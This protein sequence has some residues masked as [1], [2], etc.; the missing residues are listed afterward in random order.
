MII[1]PEEDIIMAKRPKY[2]EAQDKTN[3]LNLVLARLNMYHTAIDAAILRSRSNINGLTTEKNNCEGDYYDAYVAAKDK[4][5]L[6]AGELLNDYDAFNAKLSSAI[7]QATA[8]RDMWAAR[9]PIMEE[10]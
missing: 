4:V 8:Q 3:H 9:I 1:I 2:P 10:Y 7:T 6:E 5:L